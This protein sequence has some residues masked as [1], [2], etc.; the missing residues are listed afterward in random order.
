M[1]SLK[2]SSSIQMYTAYIDAHVVTY[3]HISGGQNNCVCTFFLGL[4]T[5]TVTSTNIVIDVIKDWINNNSISVYKMAVC[6]L[7]Y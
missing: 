2:F 3:I 6:E 1:K 5:F 7:K 4:F